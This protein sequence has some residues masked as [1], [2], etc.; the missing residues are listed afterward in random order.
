MPEEC[1]GYDGIERRK[2][3]EMV[4][5]LKQQF[6]DDQ[7]SRDEWRQ[8]IDG[9]L[10]S[11]CGFIGKIEGPYNAGLWAVRILLGAFI[12]GMVTAIIEFVRRHWN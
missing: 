10:E 2:H 7:K 5:M 1:L 11:V 12:L 4:V 8:S 9:K 3:C 6:E